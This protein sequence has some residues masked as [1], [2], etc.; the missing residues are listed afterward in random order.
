MNKRTFFTIPLLLFNFINA[1]LIHEKAEKTA[2]ART[3][4][5]LEKFNKKNVE[6]AIKIVNYL[7]EYKEDEPVQPSF[8][9]KLS[10]YLFGKN[11]NKA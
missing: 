7:L 5:L 6:A 11:S 8:F 2:D 10:N 3:A 4:D 9:T 1:D